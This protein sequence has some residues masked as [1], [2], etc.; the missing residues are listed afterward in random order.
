MKQIKWAKGST[1]PDKNGQTCKSID[2]RL[3]GTF[4]Y[5]LSLCSV[6]LSF[7][8]SVVRLWKLLYGDFGRRSMLKGERQAHKHNSQDNATQ[9]AT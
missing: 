3:H 4:L 2:I 1:G 5:S 6:Y 7:S 8:L 9:T